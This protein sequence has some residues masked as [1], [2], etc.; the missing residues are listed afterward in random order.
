MSFL[1]ASLVYFVLWVVCFIQAKPRHR[2]NILLLSSFWGIGGIVE[3]H[4]FYTYDWVSLPHLFNFD[5]GIEDFI[6]AFSMGGA[7]SMLWMGNINKLEKLHRSHFLLKKYTPFA[8][9][10]LYV[11][12]RFVLTFGFGIHSFYG[13]LFSIAPIVLL[14]SWLLPEIITDLLK[15]AL[16]FLVF[17]IVHLYT[18]LLVEEN[19]IIEYWYWEEIP[20]K[21]RLWGIPL[22]DIIW[23]VILGVFVRTIRLTWA[24]TEKL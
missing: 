13:L 24:V 19:S 14:A 23:G 10:F 22:L 21:V 18:F 8:L 7:A 3:G 11:I 6:C 12:L 1:V 5:A 17:T 15:T 2:K 20:L 9:T 16:L 4:F